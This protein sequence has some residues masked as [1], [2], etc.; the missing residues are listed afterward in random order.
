[1]ITDVTFINRT[2]IHW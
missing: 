1:M 2:T